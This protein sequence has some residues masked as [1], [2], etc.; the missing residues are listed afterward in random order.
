[1]QPSFNGITCEQSN[2]EHKIDIFT[3]SKLRMLH[4]FWLRSGDN[5]ELGQKLIY[6]AALGE[7]PEVPSMV[8]TRII[9][10][11]S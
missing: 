9:H 4:N 10:E 7:N 3:P 11:G 2:V 1:M 5:K 8:L 6:Y